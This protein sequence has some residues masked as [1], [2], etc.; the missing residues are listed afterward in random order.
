MI[1][2]ILT[3]NDDAHPL[4]SEIDDCDSSLAHDP[5]PPYPSRSRRTRGTRNRR[6]S[7]PIYTGH[8]QFPST[9]SHSDN[10]NLTSPFP[11]SDEG[12]AESLPNENTPF[13]S[14]QR[15]SNT[16]PRSLSHTSSISAAPSL[17][18]TVLSLFEDPI[19][20]DGEERALLSPE[21]RP[22]PDYVHPRSFRVSSAQSWKIYLRP[23]VQKVYYKSLFH[24]LLLNFPY[25]VISWVFLF[26]FTLVSTI[27]FLQL[28]LPVLN[29]HC[30]DW[31][32]AIDS[33]SNWSHPLFLQSPWCSCVRKRRGTCFDV[34][35]DFRL[36]SDM[37]SLQLAMQTY[38]HAPLAYPI[39]YPPR[40]I[41][42]RI[43][44]PTS[45]EIEAGVASSTITEKS[46]YKN[47]YA[48]VIIRP[49]STELH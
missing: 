5:P 36:D 2:P 28:R 11:L 9:D 30:S 29:V 45:A 15:Y 1:P 40:P 44:E 20:G 47:T 23:L 24:L 12:E 7:Q 38:F 21:L 6:P 33:P 13:L 43:R 32:N 14:P 18:H 19:N 39:P 42:T 48:M 31:N 4:S 25:A 16:R 37:F 8:S 35:A 34:I 10:E 49:L 17:A 41:F 22:L 26:V 27:S 3:A 46:F